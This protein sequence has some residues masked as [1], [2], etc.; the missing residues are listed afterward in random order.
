M[1]KYWNFY[2]GNTCIHSEPYEGGDTL[3]VMRQWWYDN[4]VA[5]KQTSTMVTVHL[6]D[7]CG[8]ES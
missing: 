1:S 6:E 4:A 7:F 3:Y 5:L 2:D 8:K